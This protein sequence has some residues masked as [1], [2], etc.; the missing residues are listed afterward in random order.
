MEFKDTINIF[1]SIHIYIK[2]KKK[3]TYIYTYN[4]Y[5]YICI[6]PI[7][8]S[9]VSG[10]GQRCFGGGDAYTNADDFESNN[11][12]F[13]FIVESDLPTGSGSL[14]QIKV[15]D[16]LSLYLFS[17]FECYDLNLL[18]LWIEIRANANK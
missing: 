15:C 14:Y 3:T 13:S 18:L 4:N 16:I 8:F 11:G 7:Y 5:T 2:K 9:K 17:F 10:G 12:V 6:S 1:T